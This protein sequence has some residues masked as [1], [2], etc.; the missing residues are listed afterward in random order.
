MEQES[1]NRN[2]DDDHVALQQYNH[3]SPNASSIRFNLGP[4]EPEPTKH[5]FRCNTTGSDIREPKQTVPTITGTDITAS[6]S[7]TSDGLMSRM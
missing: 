3:I 1:K 6:I 5:H 2:K 4:V 7:L